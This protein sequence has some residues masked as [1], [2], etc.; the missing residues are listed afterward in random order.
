MVA[1]SHWKVGSSDEECIRVHFTN[2][3]E[4]VA[5]HVL[6]QPANAL[7]AGLTKLPK[8]TTSLYRK[9]CAA[10]VDGVKAAHGLV[11][12]IPGANSRKY[13]SESLGKAVDFQNKGVSEA[14]RNGERIAKF[15]VDKNVY[16]GIKKDLIPQKG[17]NAVN[18]NANVF[19]KEGLAQSD[20]VNIGF[21]KDNLGQLNEAVK[22]SLYSGCFIFATV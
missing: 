21:H 12:P 4:D 20:K 5:S 13:V 16:S 19:N 8:A 18:P 14:A 10:E 15:S 11:P 1:N 6:N 7:A 2:V 22:V 17:A 3:K 9:M